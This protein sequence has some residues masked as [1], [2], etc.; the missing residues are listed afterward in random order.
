MQHVKHTEATPPWEREREGRGKPSQR[1]EIFLSRSCRF[2]GKPGGG[3]C[4]VLE[5]P[6][7]EERKRRRHSDKVLSVR[8]RKFT[9]VSKTFPIF[10]IV[11]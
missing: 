1:G 9:I 7:G 6:S 4:T 8:D 5:F 2:Y 11:Q 10:K 3:G